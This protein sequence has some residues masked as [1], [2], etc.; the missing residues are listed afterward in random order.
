MSERASTVGNASLSVPAGGDAELQQQT[1]HIHT[2]QTSLGGP[3]KT[4]ELSVCMAIP[5]FP[6]DVKE[7]DLNLPEKYFLLRKQNDGFQ[8]PYYLTS[9]A[10][11]AK[12]RPPEVV[13][14]WEQRLAELDAKHQKGFE[15][16]QTKVR[17]AEWYEER[18][19]DNWCCLRYFVARSYDIN[20]AFAMLEKS[21]KWRKETG[22]DEW[23]CDACKQ[24]PNGHMSQFV[25]WDKE[26]RPVLFMSMRWGPERK[27]PL[28]HM[29][30]AFNHLIKMMPV[31]IEKWVCMTDFATY[32]HLRD[33]KPSMGLSVIRTIQDHYPERLGKMIIINPPTLFWGLYKLFYPAIDPVTRT[34]VEFVYTEDKPSVYDAF[35]KLFP[36]HLRGF[37]YDSY[38]RSKHDLPAKPLVWVPNPKGYPKNNEERKQQ[39][40][41]QKEDGKKSKEAEREARHEAKEASKKEQQAAK[42]AEKERPASKAKHSSNS[43]GVTAASV[44]AAAAPGASNSQVITQ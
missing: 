22:A 38:D 17:A 40:H 5:Q 43:D 23:E 29:V 1:S 19:C 33:G 16:F 11:I 9:E 26:F 12:V 44:P 10:E 8:I 13:K 31:G 35:P 14:T 41:K 36:A 15:A 27:A 7:S 18:F 24:D 34:K 30:A 20:K 28:R 37:L 25:G 32:S 6:P 39:L 3:E 21:V 4:E 2:A 42:K